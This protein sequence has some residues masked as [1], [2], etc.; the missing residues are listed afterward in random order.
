MAR[1]RGAQLVW[2]AISGLC[3]TAAAQTL[4][5]IDFAAQRAQVI[6]LLDSVPDIELRQRH[7]RCM[8]VSSVRGLTIGETTVCALVA[9]A[10]RERAFAGDHRAMT[11]WAESQR[12]PHLSLLEP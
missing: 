11:R 7:L 9:D 3:A 12:D 2:L 10:L 1:H 5:Q 8:H 4:E 6:A